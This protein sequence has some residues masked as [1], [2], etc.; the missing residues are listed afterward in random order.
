M[1]KAG[2][3]IGL[4]AGVFGFI[5]ALV[6]L[7]FGGI[8]SALGATGGSMVVSL[9]WGGVLFSFLTIV[10][11]AVA[12]SKAKAGGWSLIGFAIGGA[13]LG[14][15]LVAICMVLALLGGILAVAG[16]PRK[17]LGAVAAEPVLGGE[18]SPVPTIDA[19]NAAGAVPARGRFMKPALIG[20]AGV[21]CLLVLVGV[22]GMNLGGA[23][24]TSEAD[25][26]SA[27]PES[28]YRPEGVISEV[29]ALGS[30]NTNLQRESAQ[31]ELTGQVINWSLPVYEVSR[32]GNNFKVQTQAKTRV[33]N[34]GTDLVGTFVIVTPRSDDERRMLASLQTGDTLSFKGRIR[35]VTMRHLHV[36]PAILSGANSVYGL[37]KV[38]PV[39]T[40]KAEVKT[41]PPVAEV[42][43]AAAPTPVP[44][45]PPMQVAVATPEPQ[46]VVAPVTAPVAVD[47]PAEKVQVAVAA[48]PKSATPSS[49]VLEDAKSC[50]DAARCVHVM[51]TAASPRRADA[52]QAAATR[53]VAFKTVTVGDRKTARQLNTKALQKFSTGAFQ[54][55]VDLL[56]QAADEDPQ[57]VEIKSNL[58]LAQV[59]AGQPKDAIASLTKALML[60]PR[61]SS[62]WAPLAEAYEQSEQ[63][64]DAAHALLLSYEFSANKQKSLEFLRDRAAKP[65]LSDSL[66]GVYASAL[67]VVQEGY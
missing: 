13:C 63:K 50:A 1:S 32:S 44:A 67:K 47:V 53:L 52:I 24:K 20:A 16:A 62:A 34:F 57:D 8:G 46:P 33:G 35:G 21:L 60:D 40:A 41:L 56:T 37:A 6:T 15:T 59:R 39:V 10:A 45:P 22:V 11:G 9:G 43:V 14:G 49:D 26:L 51:L 42:P 5:A 28:D 23:S 61:R 4:I 7:L 27:A 58:G 12:L 25:V 18:P 36:E 54:E 29:F 3:I 65:E 17:Q 30:R 55:A 2:G 19:S 66:R 31:K 48:V 64:V 38:A